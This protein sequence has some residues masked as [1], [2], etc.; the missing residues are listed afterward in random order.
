MQA[1]ADQIGQMLAYAEA[2]PHV[3]VC[4]FALE[5]GRIWRA[6]NVAAIPAESFEISAEDW[7]AAQQLGRITGIWHSHPMNGAAPSWV[8]RAMCERTRLPWH[9]VSAPDGGYELIQPSGWRAPYEGRQYCYGI[10]DCW[11]LL[12]DWQHAERG[13]VLPRLDDAPDGWWHEKDLLPEL[14]SR[15]RAVQVVGELQRGDVILMRCDHE[16]KGADHAA[17]FLGDGRMLHQLRDQR[18]QEGLY[19]GYWQRATVKVLRLT[20]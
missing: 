8:D 20:S 11:E 2:A 12:R 7:A 5:D 15:L 6:E 19:G 14:L 4:G 9:V 1:N 17:V 16:S 13:I 3:E 10:F 18:S